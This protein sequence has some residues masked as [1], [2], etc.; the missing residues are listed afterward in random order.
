[1]AFYFVS[2]FATWLAAMDKN[3]ANYAGLVTITE[4]ET[5]HMIR[6]RQLSEENIPAYK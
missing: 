4:V 1:M 5:A 2:T 6:K 3:G